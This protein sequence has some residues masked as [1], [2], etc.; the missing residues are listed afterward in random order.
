MKRL[1]KWIR[2]FFTP[3]P[4]RTVLLTAIQ[5][6][7]SGTRWQ[8]LHDMQK[9]SCADVR[10]HFILRADINQR[11]LLRS[12]EA[13]ETLDVTVNFGRRRDAAI[14]GLM[15]EFDDM[16]VPDFLLSEDTTL[17]WKRGES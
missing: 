4:T 15:L 7:P 17:I 3:P 2:R 5:E 16:L 12:I 6:R 13:G 14:H 9:G 1:L 11:T 10:L 8:T